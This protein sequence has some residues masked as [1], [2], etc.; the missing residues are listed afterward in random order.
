[1]AAAQPTQI[2]S[3]RVEGVLE[4]ARAIRKMGNDPALKAAL[5]VATKESAEIIVPA[6]KRYVPVGTRSK[7]TRRLHETVR[8]QSHLTKA[9]VMIGGAKHNYAWI[10]HNNY[11]P[12]GGKTVVKGVP[13]ARWGVSDKYE[14]FFKKYQKAIDDVIAK[15]DRKYGAKTRKD[16]MV[17]SKDYRQAGRQL[18]DTRSSK[19]HVRYPP[20]WWS[21]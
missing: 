21:E 17:Y 20:K 19:G 4:I 8:A 18:H 12:G 5:R 3:A 6:V 16:L 10:R 13:F 7:T 2:V 15:F 9:R 1:M 14:V 11:R